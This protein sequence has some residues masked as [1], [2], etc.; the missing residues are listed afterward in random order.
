MKKKKTI[1][2]WMA[3]AV[4][5]AFIILILV[6][7][8]H[9]INTGR[10]DRFTSMGG[11]VF[12]KEEFMQNFEEDPALPISKAIYAV[13]KV[14]KETNILETM[15][16]EYSK[17]MDN[18]RYHWLAVGVMDDEKNNWLVTFRE[19][20]IVPKLLCKASVKIKTGLV[21]KLECGK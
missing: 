13:V 4:P 15:K 8:T 9:T 17:H 12:D 19:N 1:K 3:L 14:R 2:F 11:M 6:R 16:V 10:N 5:L 18:K 20:H 21:S 7:L